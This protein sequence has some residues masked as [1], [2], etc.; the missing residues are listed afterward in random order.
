MLIPAILAA[1]P[2]LKLFNVRAIDKVIHS[3]ISISPELSASAFIG[4]SKI[5]P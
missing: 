5:S 4:L 3:L 2:T 1:I